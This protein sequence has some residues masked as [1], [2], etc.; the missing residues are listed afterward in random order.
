MENQ[1]RTEEPRSYNGERKVSLIS[2]LGKLDSH[3]QKNESKQYFSPYTKIN[4]KW[5]KDLKVRSE[6]VKLLEENMG[7]TFF[8]IGRSSILSNTMS[9]KAR[10]TKEKINK[11]DY[12]RLKS[13]YKAKETMNK[14]K[15]Q[16]PNWEKIFA[17]HI[18]DKGLISKLYKELIQLNNKKNE[19]FDQKMGRG[20]E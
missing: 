2:G 10:E 18:S 14:T 6:T 16:P 13:F 8:D 7:S 1:F 19:Q 11:W 15:R 9:T 12:I 3:M 5:I 17:N 20:Y 4:L